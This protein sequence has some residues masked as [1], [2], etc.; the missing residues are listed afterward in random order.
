M[1]QRSE[2][3]SLSVEQRWFWNDFVLLRFS[4]PFTRLP[5][6]K[7]L[8]VGKHNAQWLHLFRLCDSLLNY[9]V[10]KVKQRQRSFDIIRKVDF[11]RIPSINCPNRFTKTCRQSF[12]D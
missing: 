3:E 4:C 5:F 11:T 2:N 10:D 6:S 9:H 12:L 8:Q 1:S 7:G